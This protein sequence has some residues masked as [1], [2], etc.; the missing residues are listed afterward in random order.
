M[1][2][3]ETL[4]RQLYQV[5]LFHPVKMGLTNITRLHE[6]LGNPAD[7][8]PAVHIAGT[9]GKGSVAFKMARS[10]QL[11]GL[12]TG[13]FVSPHM[14]CFRERVQVDGAYIPESSIEDILPRIFDLCE[15]EDIPATFFEVTTAL[16][17]Q[18]F[19]ESGVDAIVVETGLGGRLDA[20]NILKP[21]LTVVTS[22]GLDHTRILGDTV[23]QIALEKAGIFKPGVPALVGD[24]CPVDIMRGVAESGGCPFH[25]WADVF[26]EG[27]NAGDDEDYDEENTRLAEAGLVLLGRSHP[28]LCVN[29][30]AL[31]RGVTQRPPCRFE[32]LQ[33]DAP[34][35]AAAAEAAA[36]GKKVES[37]HSGGEAGAGGGGSGGGG[38]VTV[39][40]DVAH[41]PP[42]I[43]RFFQKA[44]TRRATSVDVL[45]SRLSELSG[46][47][48]DSSSSR[49]R[50]GDES[51]RQAL[52]DA[53]AEASLSGDGGE[54]S[55][56]DVVVVCGTVFMMVD[57]REELG[58]NEPRDNL[59]RTGTDG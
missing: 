48:F 2:R 30:D 37:S 23:E 8:L 54:G 29:E 13:L 58:F 6:A 59:V 25:R 12:K 21:A 41:N 10:L 32:V 31:R 33:V 36:T 42:A 11:G 49:V 50:R 5:N 14:S 24:G 52:R 9:N 35:A 16:A 18:H 20:T 46:G 26:P 7:G 45:A 40:L 1:R 47:R 38:V 34:A 51:V 39:V 27:T 28:E 19:R 17:F 15:S 56:R 4:V 3:Y 22:V 44:A 57:I 53:I 55:E 43:V